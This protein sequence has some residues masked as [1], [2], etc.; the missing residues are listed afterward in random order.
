MAGWF[1]TQ[2]RSGEHNADYADSIDSSLAATARGLRTGPGAIHQRRQRWKS[3]PVLRFYQ[4]HVSEA[5]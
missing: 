3:P 1:Q 4:E 2:R 5:R